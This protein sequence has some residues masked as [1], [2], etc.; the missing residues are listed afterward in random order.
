MILLIILI[1]LVCSIGAANG[2]FLGTGGDFAIYKE[3]L[4]NLNNLNLNFESINLVGS[5]LWQAIRRYGFVWVSLMKFHTLLFGDN[6]ELFNFNLSFITLSVKFYFFKVLH[7]DKYQTFFAF[8]LYL[9]TL[10]ILQEALRIRASLS[11]CF[12]IAFVYFLNKSNNFKSFN[13]SLYLT[14]SIIFLLLSFNINL[15]GFFLSSIF[16]IDFYSDKIKSIIKLI[17]FKS[18]LT[19]LTF[20]FLVFIAAFIFKYIFIDI[21]LISGDKGLIPQ[22]FPYLVS[23]SNYFSALFIIPIILTIFSHNI[24][25]L[26][27]TKSFRSSNITPFYIS[28]ILGIVLQS[29]YLLYQVLNMSYFYLLSF[30][31]NLEN[32]NLLYIFLLLTFYYVSIRTIPLI[33]IN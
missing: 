2:Y 9:S 32:K 5:D 31:D 28:L 11:V 22:L 19:K 17:N 20:S 13:K 14:I 30:K 1:I 27:K 25:T 12:A 26:V 8:L 29:Q 23:E 18:L 21:L 10:Y 33:I 4:L 24:L 15:N 6:F 16:L 7:K 3:L